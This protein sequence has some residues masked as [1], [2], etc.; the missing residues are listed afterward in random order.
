M[1]ELPWDDEERLPALLRQ[2]EQTASEQLVTL[3]REYHVWRAHQP[4]LRRQIPPLPMERQPWPGRR[5]AV[6]LGR[7]QEDIRETLEDLEG[8]AS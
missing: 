7:L 8:G 2:I 5:V 3:R 1:S 4:E 6:M